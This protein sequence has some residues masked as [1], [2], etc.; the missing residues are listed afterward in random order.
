MK[1]IL[2]HKELFYKIFRIYLETLCIFYIITECEF[3]FSI[4]ISNRP[5]LRNL[6]IV[7]S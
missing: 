3:L 6:R 4:H 7:R 2:R 1:N 5:R